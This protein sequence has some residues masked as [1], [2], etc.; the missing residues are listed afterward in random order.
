MIKNTTYVQTPE[1]TYRKILNFTSLKEWSITHEKMP[2][3]HPASKIKCNIPFIM[4]GECHE[5]ET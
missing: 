4:D 5:N 3:D 2:E 1:G